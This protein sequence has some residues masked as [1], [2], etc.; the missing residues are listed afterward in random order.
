MKMNNVFITFYHKLH[1]RKARGLL[2]KINC[3]HYRTI[4][5]AFRVIED[6]ENSA[7]YITY[8][9]VFLGGNSVPVTNNCSPNELIG[10]ETASKSLWFSSMQ[11]SLKTCHSYV[12]F[13]RFLSNDVWGTKV[14]IKNMFYP[15]IPASQI[16]IPPYQST[17]LSA[18]NTEK[19]RWKTDLATK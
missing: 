13:I 12:N 7:N 11:Y 10:T 16:C 9:L 14:V 3:P 17:K 4:G 18:W 1:F 8:I 2:G 15:C 5:V 19:Q 6:P